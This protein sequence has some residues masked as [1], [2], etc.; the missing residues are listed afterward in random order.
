MKI[1]KK[2]FSHSFL[3]P[4]T[5]VVI[6]LILMIIGMSACSLTVTPEELQ[7]EKEME[8][9]EKEKEA[10]IKDG[11]RFDD[12]FV[13]IVEYEYGEK[14]KLDLETGCKYIVDGKRMSIKGKNKQLDCDMKYVEE[15][16]NR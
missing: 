2:I 7:E 3:G 6:F 4:F 15:Y 9:K 11:G 1:I 5:I 12:S 13:T 8:L 16:L 14:I 10:K